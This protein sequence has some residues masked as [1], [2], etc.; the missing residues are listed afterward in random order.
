MSQVSIRSYFEHASPYH[1]FQ[2][3]RNDIARM[4][5]IGVASLISMTCFVP[6]VISQVFNLEQGSQRD[7]TRYREINVGVA[8]T[9]WFD[10]SPG[11]SILTVHRKQKAESKLFLEYG[12][13][14]ALPTLLTGKVGFGITG[15]SNGNL[16]AGIRVYP[17][18]GYLRVGIPVQTKRRMA[19]LGFSI[20]KSGADINPTL[21]EL[22]FESDRMLTVGL[23]MDIR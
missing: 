19:E 14:L 3:M 15:K 20:E 4:F 11:M 7:I 17:T 10:V 21:R 12:Y 16:S 18:H 22:S 8:E 23:C 2:M 6:P 13:G 5:R 9:S 1:P